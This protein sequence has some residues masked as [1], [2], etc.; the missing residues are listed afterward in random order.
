MDEAREKM[1]DVEPLR[2]RIEELE[3]ENEKLREAMR[4]ISLWSFEA[5][6]NTPAIREIENDILRVRAALNG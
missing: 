6:D 1:R 5:K 4:P 3:A 2:A